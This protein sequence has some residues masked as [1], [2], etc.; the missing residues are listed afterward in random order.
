MLSSLVIIDGIMNRVV[1]N[2][3]SQTLS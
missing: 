2:M 3:C 1:Y